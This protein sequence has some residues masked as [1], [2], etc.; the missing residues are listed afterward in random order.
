MATHREAPTTIVVWFED[1][2]A[3][4][5]ALEQAQ[6]LADTKGAHLTVL[7]IA[8]H[9][10]VI[11]CG[12]CLQGTVLWNLEM[13]KMAH[14]TLNQAKELL[15]ASIHAECEVVVGDPVDQIVAAAT[16]HQANTIVLPWQRN[17]RLDPP[18]RRN[19][20][21]RLT[22]KGS[23]QVIVAPEPGR[24]QKVELVTAQ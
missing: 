19:L 18:A 10:R 7:T 3:G 9:E 16:N 5:L 22:A 24:H 6:R 13:Q 8:I 14:E 11:G 21:Q 2:A 20:A 12:R 4:R 1:S 17:R 23:W 15:A